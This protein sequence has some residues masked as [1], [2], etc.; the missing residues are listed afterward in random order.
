M[1]GLYAKTITW[2][3]GDDIETQITVIKSYPVFQKVA[4]KLGITQREKKKGGEFKENIAR[5]AEGLQSKVE[6]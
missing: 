3:G 5:I 6:V 1:E 2:S 4:E